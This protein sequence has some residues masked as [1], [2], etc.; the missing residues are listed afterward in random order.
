M[1][2]NNASLIHKYPKTLKKQ[3]VQLSSIISHRFFIL[4]LPIYLKY[5]SRPKAKRVLSYILN[6]CTMIYEK[7]K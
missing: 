3:H 4:T 1:K 6:K 2:D 5:R 7:T